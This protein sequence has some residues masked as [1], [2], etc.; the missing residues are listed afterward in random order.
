MV[1]W[2][3]TYRCNLKC[4][5]CYCVHNDEK[6]E[7]TLN[8]SK[9]VIDT[10]ADMQSL[11]ITFS[12]GEILMREDFF[13]I[14][15]YARIKGFALRFLT[16][17]TLINYKIADDIKQLNPLSVEMSLYASYADL[18]DRIIGMEG[19]FE[20][21]IRAFEMLRERGVK[22]KVK[23]L[24]MRQNAGELAELRSLAKNLDSDLV[25]DMVVFPKDDGTK[26]P[27]D[28]RLDEKDISGIF[29]SDNRAVSFEPLKEV[30]DDTFMCSA[31]LNNLL[32]SPYGDIFPCVGMKESAGNLRLQSIKEIQNSSILQRV[33]STKFSE[34]WACR[35]CD[36]APYC[37][38][39]PGL[40]AAEDGDYLGPSSAACR[41]AGRLKNAGNKELRLGV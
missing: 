15:H 13:S 31:G 7:L 4:V 14:A 17:G 29:N 30:N 34:L 35:K 38:R 5:H 36:L 16:N 40:A 10:L 39:C 41:L 11:Y 18:H 23:S 21:T 8:E 9:S 28:F 2:E 25:Y 20:K 3:L 1:Q 32:I 27:L 6:Q 19:A 26:G 24:L 22:T 12:G 37:R 33:R